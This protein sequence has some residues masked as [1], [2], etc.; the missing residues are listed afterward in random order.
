MDPGVG[1]QWRRHEEFLSELYIHTQAAPAEAWRE[2]A[3]SA[4]FLKPL[5]A[6]MRRLGLDAGTRRRLTAAALADAAPDSLAALDAA[7]RLV[8]SLLQD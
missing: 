2:W 8:E 4:D 5:D 6:R 1:R 3:G 7:V